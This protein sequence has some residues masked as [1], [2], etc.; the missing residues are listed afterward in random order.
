[1]GGGNE[2]ENVEKVMHIREYVQKGF[3]VPRC[4]KVKNLDGLQVERPCPYG[5]ECWKSICINRN[6]QSTKC[7]KSNTHW[8]KADSMQ[9]VDMYDKELR[10][11]GTLRCKRI[12]KGILHTYQCTCRN[13]EE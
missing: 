11:W 7:A 1:M 6:I 12:L 13:K 4:N 2:A 8:F 5:L 9:D 10:P 3:L